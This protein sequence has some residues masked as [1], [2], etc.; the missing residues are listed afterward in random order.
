MGASA[1]ARSL[2][3]GAVALPAVCRAAAGRQARRRLATALH[4]AGLGHFAFPIH[5]PS[6]Y[7]QVPY[8]DRSCPAI[9]PYSR[10][11]AGDL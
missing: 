3:R 11:F 6:D 7:R 2:P 10:D 5:V 9:T 8:R 4:L 1:L